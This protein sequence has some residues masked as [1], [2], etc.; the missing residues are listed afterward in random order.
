MEANY[1]NKPCCTWKPT[2]AGI[3]T[4]IVGALNIIVGIAAS[5]WGSLATM[6]NWYMFG[7]GARLGSRAA[8]I[9]GI[10]LIVIGIISVI[11]GISA[12]KRRKWGLAL[13]GAILALFPPPAIVLGILSIIFLALSKHEFNQI[14][15]TTSGGTII[16]PETKSGDGSSVTPTDKV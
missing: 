5:A 6:R 10:I 11:G 3:L 4:I 15:S 12:L 13:A 14:A 1:Q 9:V 7:N 8:L 16:K 2:V